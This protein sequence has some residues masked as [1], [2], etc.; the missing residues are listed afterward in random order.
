MFAGIKFHQITQMAIK[1]KLQ[2]FQVN[3]SMCPPSC[4]A[5]FWSLVLKATSDRS[6][7]E[8]FSDKLA[9][10][11]LSIVLIVICVIWWTYFLLNHQKRVKKS[12]RFVQLQTLFTPKKDRN[13]DPLLW[14]HFLT[15]FQNFGIKQNP[16]ASRRQQKKN[17]ADISFHSRVIQK[18]SRP[19]VVGHPV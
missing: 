19:E 6:M 14:P 12:F 10:F 9:W 15:D 17:Y 3:N 8:G 16:K 11:P 5:H 1:T 4:S 13:F 18:Q 2:H 7:V